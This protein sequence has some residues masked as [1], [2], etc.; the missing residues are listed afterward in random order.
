MIALLALA[1]LG[2]VGSV[3]LSARP[4][5]TLQRSAG[6]ELEMLGRIGRVPSVDSIRTQLDRLPE[7]S[8]LREAIA[9]VLDASTEGEAVYAVTELSFL[10]QSDVRRVGYLPRVAGRVAMALGALSGLVMLS[11][12]IPSGD[13]AVVPA[14]IAF[15]AGVVAAVLCTLIGRK[16]DM[17]IEARREGWNRVLAA[18][19]RVAEDTH[20]PTSGIAETAAGPSELG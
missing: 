11:Q 7:E 16:L 14:A 8:R 4:L 17:L 13:V 10:A 5:L 3:W 19:G 18:L 1:L 15:A 6:R 12:S 20:A 2:A 9:A